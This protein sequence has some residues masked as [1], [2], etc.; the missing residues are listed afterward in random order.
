MSTYPLH[1]D[2]DYTPIFQSEVDRIYHS[3]KSIKKISGAIGVVL[4]MPV[5]TFYFTIRLKLLIGRLESKFKMLLAEIPLMSERAQI[6]TEL[7]WTRRKM[8]ADDQ[9]A[10]LLKKIRIIGGK[11]Y[12]ASTI[13]KETDKLISIFNQNVEKITALVYP[14]N[15]QI[16]SP[17]FLDDLKKKYTHIDNSDWDDKSF[18]IYDQKF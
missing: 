5:V 2:K 1:T 12:F 13:I 3:Y 16:N 17:E 9:F 18:D 8:L 4:V 15:P 7:K 6:E 10:P 14:F 11:S